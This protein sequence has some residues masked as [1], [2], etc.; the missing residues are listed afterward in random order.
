VGDDAI[1]DLI[2]S[3]VDWDYMSSTNL[4]RR[5]SDGFTV[6]AVQLT[7]YQGGRQAGKNYVGQQRPVQLPYVPTH[8]TVVLWKSHGKFSYAAIYVALTDR[9][10]I[11]G[12]G[13][14][15]GGNELTRDQ[16]RAVL[17][18]PNT[19]ERTIVSDIIPLEIP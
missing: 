18:D 4:Y 16:F 19:S 6:T 11:T 17:D 13:Q 7:Q 8:G 10:Y 12:T 5:R 14:Q 9:W 3:P 15:Y 1:Q 2:D